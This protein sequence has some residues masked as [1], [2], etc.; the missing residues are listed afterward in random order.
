MKAQHTPTPWTTEM[1]GNHQW[2]SAPFLLMADFGSGEQGKLDA[3]FIV[4][5]VNSHEALVEA[6]KHLIHASSK[7]AIT[8]GDVMIARAALKLA[9]E[10]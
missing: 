3:A 6:L 5:A 9:G 8:V 10:E 7:D 2:I 4:K 1:V